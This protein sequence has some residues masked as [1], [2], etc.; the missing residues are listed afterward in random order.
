MARVSVAAAFVQAKMP[1]GNVPPRITRQVPEW[2]DTLNALARLQQQLVVRRARDPVENDS[3][4]R[5]CRIEGR[6]SFDN[7]RRAPAG[8]DASR[9]RG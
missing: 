4:D 7:G 9:I 3:G 2:R 1:L 5:H 6:E 8:H